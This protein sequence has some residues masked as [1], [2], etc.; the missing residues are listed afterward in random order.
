MPALVGEQHVVS[1]KSTRAALLVIALLS[2]AIALPDDCGALVGKTLLADEG[3][4]PLNFAEKRNDGIYL[5]QVIPPGQ[6]FQVIGLTP[7]HYGN[8]S[9]TVLTRDG[10]ELI[11]SCSQLLSA[12]D[13]ATPFQRVRRA[14]PEDFAEAQAIFKAKQDANDAEAARAEAANQAKVQADLAELQRKREEEKRTQE[15]SR[16]RAA[17]RAQQ[18]HDAAVKER[19]QRIARGGVRIGM[20]EHEVLVSSWGEP[21]QRNHTFTPQGEAEQ[22]VYGSQHILYFVNGVLTTIQTDSPDTGYFRVAH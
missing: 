7:V 20:S 15:D 22:W 19:E 6:K 18:E 13:P 8:D 16:A 5:N 10:R 21:A 9:Y 11:I 14:A 12:L 1:S 17:K 2:P 3:Q 4:P